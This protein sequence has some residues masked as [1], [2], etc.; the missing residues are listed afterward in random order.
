MK[1]KDNPRKLMVNEEA[2]KRLDNEIIQELSKRKN[3][4]ANKIKELIAKGAD[5]NTL[6]ANGWT[7]LIIA[8][9][10]RRHRHDQIAI[11]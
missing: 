9:S 6:G 5:V 2:A 3:A 1:L 7:P 11:G 10:F 4:D 8:S